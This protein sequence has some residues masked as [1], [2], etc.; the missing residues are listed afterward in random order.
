M[1]FCMY[2]KFY[3]VHIKYILYNYGNI[4][5]HKMG[6]KHSHTS[7]QTDIAVITR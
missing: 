6:A 3:K 1:H 4:C 2:L 5:N 7:S